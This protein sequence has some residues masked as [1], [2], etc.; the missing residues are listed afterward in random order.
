MGKKSDNIAFYNGKTRGVKDENT[1]S[2][3]IKTYKHYKQKN[4]YHKKND[5]FKINKKKRKEWEKKNNRK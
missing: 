2:N 5:Y 3:S 1:S 4:P